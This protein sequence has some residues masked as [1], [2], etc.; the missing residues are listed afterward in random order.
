MSNFSAWF[1]WF[2]ASFRSKSRSSP[3]FLSSSRGGRKAAWAPKWWWKCAVCSFVWEIGPPLCWSPP[4]YIYVFRPHSAESKP[5]GPFYTA[6]HSTLEAFGSV[7]TRRLWKFVA[8]FSLG[9]TACIFLSFPLL[10]SGPWFC[11]RTSGAS[12]VLSL[13]VRQNSLEN[14]QGCQKCR[15]GPG[16][17]CCRTQSGCFGLGYQSAKS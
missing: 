16:R 1:S 15:L 5:P 8:W 9:K 11:W 4:Y 6:F 7:L 17:W 3:L 14:G 12:G 13:L 2:W 10:I